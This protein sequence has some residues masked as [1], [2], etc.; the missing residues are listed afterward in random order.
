MTSSQHP[1]E[2]VNLRNPVHFFALGFGSG[3]LR[4]APGTWGSLVGVILGALLLPVLGAKTFFILTALCFFIGIWL[5]ERT[6]HDMGVHDHG[7]IVWDEIVAVF[8]VLLA[9]PQVSLLW[10]AIAF[11]TFRL[12]DILKPYPIRYFDEKLTN[13]FGIMVDD[14]LAAGY[15]IVVIFVLAHFI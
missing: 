3:L 13:G 4:P 8:L 5:C 2:R 12:F 1:L 14:I 9:V 15:S 7:S 11:V 6:S 10:C